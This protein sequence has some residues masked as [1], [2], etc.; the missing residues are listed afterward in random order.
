MLRPNRTNVNIV[1]DKK[2]HLQEVSRVSPI[3]KAHTAL[4]IV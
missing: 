3:G 1:Q 4:Y 2:T